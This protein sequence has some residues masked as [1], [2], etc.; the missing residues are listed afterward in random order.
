MTV[1]ASNN[2]GRCPELRFL[3]CRSYFPTD[4][5][6]RRAVRGGEPI[7]VGAA[8]LLPRKRSAGAPLAVLRRDAP[9]GIDQ[10]AVAR[11]GL[12]ALHVE[13]DSIIGIA[14]ALRRDAAAQRGGEVGRHDARDGAAQR[15]GPAR[16]LADA[17]LVRS[18]AHH[19]LRAVD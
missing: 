9:G 8:P 19:D 7:V 1:I 11:R 13:R 2:Y 12:E 6:E 17:D 3:Y 5:G 16:L 10:H 15:L 18:H 14:R 4:G